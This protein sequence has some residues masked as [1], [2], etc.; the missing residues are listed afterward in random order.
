M[1]TPAL[2][3]LALCAVGPASLCSGAM[4]A[5]RA[6]GRLDILSDGQPI[7]SYQY[8]TLPAPEGT[9]PAFARGGFVHPLRTPAG[10]V[11]TRIQPPDHPH[12]YGIWNPWTH[13]EFRGRVTDMW[14][15]G[16]KQ[17]TVR[18]AGFERVTSLPGEAGFSAIHE[19]VIFN[20]DGTETVA[21]RERQTWMAHP[22]ASGDSI[23]LDLTIELSCATD[24]PVTLLE[25]RYGGPGRR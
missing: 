7:L 11:L 22:A 25:Y 6:D 2:A 18:F 24:D 10:H 1:K 14:N 12:H 8:E 19:H 13:V 16:D 21:L 3:L 4:S 15:L 17:G 20:A 23:I 5:E 9:D